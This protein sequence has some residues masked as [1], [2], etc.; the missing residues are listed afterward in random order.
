MKLIIDKGELTLPS[1]FSFE[2]EK[3]SAFFSE[4]GSSSIGA[5]IPATPSDQAK[6]GYPTRLGR[7]NKYANIYQAIIQSGVYQKKGMLI[8]ASA[9]DESITCSMA[10]DDSE[11][12]SKNKDKNLRDI[13][14]SEELT[15][16]TTASGWSGYIELIYTGA[17]N[18]DFR[19]VPVAVNYDEST[20]KYQVNNEPDTSYPDLVH[21]PRQVKEGDNMVSVPEGYGLAPFLKLP[22]FISKLF[23]LLGYNVGYNCFEE[24][25]LLCNLILLHNC[26]DV[27]CN[28]KLKYSDCV[29]NKSVSEILEWL[30]NKF[31]AQ[32]AVSPE[33]NTV[34]IML[35]DTVLATK[36]DHDLTAEILGNV[37]Y[38]FEKSSRVIITP[39]TSLEGATPAEETLPDLI[40]KYGGYVEYDEESFATAH[41]GLAF[42]K[43]TGDF[44]MAR[45][46]YMVRLGTNYFKFDR[47]N[48]DNSEEFQPEDLMPP[49]VFVNGVLMPYIGDRK[50]R[51]TTYKDSKQDTEQDIIIAQYVGASSGDK[52]YKYAT[53]Q[54]YSDTGTSL[55]SSYTLN[56]EEFY[57]QFFQRYANILLNN[58]ISISGKFNLSIEDIFKYD[59]YC[60]KQFRGQRLLPTYLKYEIGRKIQC[61]EAKFILVKDFKDGI[62]DERVAIPSVP[63]KW[64]F[65]DDDWERVTSQ[66]PPYGMDYSYAFAESDPYGGVWR[67]AFSLPSPEYVGQESYHITRV[68]D[69]WE[70]D[71]RAGSDSKR[72]LGT[73]TF[74]QWYVVVPA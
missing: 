47:R 13:F 56:A 57:F 36:S 6:L 49:M 64:E 28:G 68:L 50:H 45:N 21:K 14:A 60:L 62:S 24:H 52:K 42:R 48:S 53:T 12:Y 46:G 20:K 63:L 65:C 17:V 33:T 67:P 39:D 27:I 9:T 1:D 30:E 19:V 38:A 59:L 10:L 72:Y 2:I 31:H 26:S 5:T 55:S 22:A 74:E 15:N 8:V 35:L 41:T 16:Y 51:N 18:N 61:L 23:T 54:R 34:D 25:P 43:A 4:E 70:E 11:L 37:N 71:L 73:V 3:N 29:P 44:Y 40:A 69:M 58:K 7:K 32:I 66:E